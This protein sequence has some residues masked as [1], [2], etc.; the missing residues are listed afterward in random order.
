MKDLGKLLKEKRRDTPTAW[1]TF[2]DTF[3]VEVKYIERRELRRIIKKASKRAWIKHQPVEDIDENKMA[4]EMEE[5]ISNWRGLTP[6]I[7]AKILPVDISGMKNEEIPCT[8]ENK[9]VLLKEAYDF[10]VFIQET[11]TDLANFEEEIQ[12][13]EVKNL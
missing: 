1:A 8:Y 7:L 12:E 2:M 11:C 10:D 3:E 4:E 13:E 9:I 5:L 6:E